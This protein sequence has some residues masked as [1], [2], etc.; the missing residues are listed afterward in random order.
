MAWLGAALPY[1]AVQGTPEKNSA[2]LRR[3]PSVH[4]VRAVKRKNRG[5]QQQD[6]VRHQE[7]V[8]VQKHTEHA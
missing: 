7:G 8:R 2:T 1:R 4:K 6:K 3:N 5:Y